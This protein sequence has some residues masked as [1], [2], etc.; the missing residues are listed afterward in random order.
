M[1]PQGSKAVTESESSEFAAVVSASGA[2]GCVECGKC[3]SVCPMV[4]MYPSFSYEMS[5][6]GL[7]RKAQGDSDIIEDES[8]WYCA[9][10][11]ACTETCPEGVSCRDLVRGLKEIALAS[12]LVKNVETCSSCGA[13]YV[14]VP[15]LGYIHQK[16]EGVSADYLDLCLWCRRQIYLRRNA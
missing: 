10:C 9:D 13:L 11:N 5:P 1:P 2:F 3:V 7:L 14:P 8:I 6:R 4:D 12:G 15:V 16:L